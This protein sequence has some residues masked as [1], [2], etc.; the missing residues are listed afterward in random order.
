M[1]ELKPCPWCGDTPKQRSAFVPVGWVDDEPV[2]MEQF[3]RECDNDDCPVQPRT[4]FYVTQEA[5]DK[6][7]NTRYERTC[8]PVNH[9]PIRGVQFKTLYCSECDFML[10]DA[11]GDPF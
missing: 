1:G 3:V 7:W 8:K 4:D 2:L 10:D 5:A 6:A 11:C 9:E